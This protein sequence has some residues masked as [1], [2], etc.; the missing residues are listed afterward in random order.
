MFFQ[1]HLL[2]RALMCAIS[3]AVAATASVGCNS[4]SQYG[5]PTTWQDYACTSNEDCAIKAVPRCC[6]AAHE[7]FNECVNKDYD[8]PAEI[9]C[10]HNKVCAGFVEP[11][12]CVCEPSFDP[13]NPDLPE[14]LCAAA[15][16]SDPDGGR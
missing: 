16:D 13:S 2:R 5:A 12:S 10:S 4:D 1:T 11:E 6:G 15:S 8:P 14:R 3:A 7:T 9:D